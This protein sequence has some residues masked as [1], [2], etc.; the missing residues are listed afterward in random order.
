[1]DQGL[2]APCGMNCRICSSYLALKYDLEK[3][4]IQRT[5][6]AGCRTQGRNCAL[7]RGCGSLRQRRLEYCYQCPEYPCPRLRRLDKRYRTHYHMSMIENLNH[8]R[9]H[10]ID[11]LLAKEA[12]KWKC[13]ACG[14]VI[15]CHNGICFGC[16][17]DKLKGK[18]KRY[19]WEDDRPE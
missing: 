8:I 13:P 17:L 9:E 5:Y 15:C 11:S 18:R 4:G 14:E 12:E 10:G 6:C 7:K 1:M 16:G 2:I 19:R 3:Q